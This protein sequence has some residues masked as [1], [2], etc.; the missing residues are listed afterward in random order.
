MHTAIYNCFVKKFVKDDSDKIEV[1]IHKNLTADNSQQ[2]FVIQYPKFIQTVV[3]Q[4]ADL[5]CLE[6]KLE[7]LMLACFMF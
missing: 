7:I 2:P 1:L 5:Q 6:A 4:N 3:I